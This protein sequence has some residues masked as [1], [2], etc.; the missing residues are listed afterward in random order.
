MTR[1]SRVL[2]FVGGLAAALAAWIWWSDRQS[3]PEA[4]AVAEE[5]PAAS[6]VPREDPELALPAPEVAQIPEES[7]R[8]AAPATP[9]AP[10]N[11]R[12]VRKLWLTGSVLKL[13]G[14]VPRASIAVVAAPPDA[15]WRQ[16]ELAG[17]A[18]VRAVNVTRTI[19][20]SSRNF[21]FGVAGTSDQFGGFRIDITRLDKSESLD[22]LRVLW[23]RVSVEGS[24]PS[25][26]DMALRPADVQRAGGRDNEFRVEL[27]LDAEC[28]VYAKALLADK[29]EEDV[30]LVALEL[31]AKL[32]RSDLVAHNFE[33]TLDGRRGFRVACGT[34]YLM[35]AYAPGYRPRAQRFV[36]A[37]GLDLGEFVLE[38]GASLSGHV[39]LDGE[40]VY[41]MIRAQLADDADS[42][43]V[44]AVRF[45]WRDEHLEWADVT[46]STDA[47]GAFR[48]EGLAPE[49]HR[50][51]L[52]AV[53]GG[54]TTP[55]SIA[56]VR[57]PAA[58]LLLS[59]G[60]A[61]VELRVFD[62]GAPVAAFLLQVHERSP[63]GG[64]GGAVR[65]DASGSAFV[66]LQPD[67]TTKLS[68]ETPAKPDLPPQRRE[69]TLDFPGV[70]QRSVVRIDL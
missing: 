52:H 45:R 41:G 61:R 1:N 56:E 63:Q 26:F 53:R 35:V 65:T 19:D 55:S 34:E 22:S 48:I 23:I 67:R 20:A 44:G 10:T 58:G 59:V 36:A 38:R 11:S 18:R 4:T 33:T 64:G 28:D 62:Q 8:E 70:G 40:G 17:P 5:A 13:S 24:E 43:H 14:I 2:M 7:E 49:P 12:A 3:A 68:F 37:H 9:A 6:A 29:G 32:G 21:A 15:E 31:A 30:Q 46:T 69:L 47:E 27:S 66:W 51:S 50:L 57:A 60:A 39:L 54:F 16:P 42:L 25:D